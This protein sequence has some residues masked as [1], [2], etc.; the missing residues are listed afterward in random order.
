MH[1]Q[2]TNRKRV[3]MLNEALLKQYVT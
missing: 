1:P 2:V 3:P